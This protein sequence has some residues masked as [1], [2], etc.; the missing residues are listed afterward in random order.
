MFAFFKAFVC[1]IARVFC[2]R[3][4]VLVI[5]VEQVSKC[6]CLPVQML[7]FFPLLIPWPMDRIEHSIYTYSFLSKIQ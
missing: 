5:L 4:F 6:S 1:A 3:V 7:Q 2:S